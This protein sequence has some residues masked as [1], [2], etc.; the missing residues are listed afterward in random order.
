LRTNPAVKLALIYALGIYLG[1]RLSLVNPT[2][3]WI[4]A[5]VFTILAFPLIRKN[6]SEYLLWIAVLALGISSGS[7]VHRYQQSADTFPEGNII[8]SGTLVDEEYTTDDRSV[9][10]LQTDWSSCDGLALESCDR[11]LRYITSP[12][13]DAVVGSQGIVY[14]ISSP[15]PERRNPGGRDL[16]KDFARRGI[17]GWIKPKYQKLTHPVKQSTPLRH[18]IEAQMR[19]SLPE[20]QAS[21]LTGMILGDKQQ[22]PEEITLDFQHSGLYHLLAVSGLHIGYLFAVLLLIIRPLVL[23]LHWRRILLAVGLWGY[24]LLT[25]ANPPTLRAAIMISLVLLSYEV[26]RIPRPWNS[27]GTAAFIILVINPGELFKAGFQLS[28]TAM[29]GV[30]FVMNLRKERLLQLPVMPSKSIKGKRFAEEALFYPVMTGLCVV[31]FTAPVLTAHFGGFAPVAVLLNLAAIPLA[32]VLFGLTWGFVIIQ[33]LLGVTIPALSGA[34]EL[35]LTGLITLAE[36]GAKLPGNATDNTG[37]FAI[38]AVMAITLTM[39]LL[40]SQFKRKILWG[41]A[42]FVVILL[43]PLLSFSPYLRIECL[44]VGQGDATLLRFPG[45][46]NVLVDCGDENAARFE[47]VP[48]LVRRNLKRVHHLIVTHY[49]RDHANG[50]LVLMK[51]VKIDRLIV[52]S[53]FTDDA[54]GRKL[55][56]TAN[57]Y[58]IAVKAV[59]LGDT[60]QFSR[61][62]KC[63]VLSPI[64]PGNGAENQHSL[65]LKIAYGEIDL[66]MSGDIGFSEEKALL[67]AGEYLQSELLKVPHHGSK[68]SSGIE[69]L[70]AVE[71]EWA[72]I[73]CGKYNPYGHPTKRV[74]D[75]LKSL[76]AAIHR[77]DR[78]NAA[79]FESNGRSLWQ[80]DWR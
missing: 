41:F 61:Q 27:W 6:T 48:S 15:Y 52:P 8:A 21:L 66:L 75:D 26:S 74:L 79:V 60:L 14:G 1:D 57:H 53:K 7:W 68:Y 71:P 32:G 80:V 37:G 24:V 72:V 17:S 50:A 12:S 58:G 63:I 16:R 67:T 46:S 59:S 62:S 10:L 4:T 2:L 34:L 39:I 76:G 55:L 73:S 70:T 38:A 33:S 13:D 49:D 40:T 45:G 31:F 28:F 54:I 3:L 11:I 20:H 5:S 43:L 56:D 22:L 25:G 78:Q 9:Y 36:I 23:N 19:K 30:I 64:Q 44:D 35:G 29:V 77:T 47:I 69:F 65:V 51:S 42:G 18:S